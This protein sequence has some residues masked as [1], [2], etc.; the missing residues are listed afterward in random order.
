MWLHMVAWWG[1]MWEH[2][3]ANWKIRE[4][5]IAYGRIW[6]HIAADGKIL[7]QQEEAGI[8]TTLVFN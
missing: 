6:E 1:G 4:H 5:M 2:M 3:K 7:E 8:S